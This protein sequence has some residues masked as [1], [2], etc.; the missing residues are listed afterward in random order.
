MPDE[1]DLFPDSIQAKELHAEGNDLY[2]KGDFLGAIDRFTQAL[3][4]WP[5]LY[6]AYFNRAL[7]RTRIQDYVPALEDLNKCVELNPGA[8]DAFYTRGLVREYRGD[9]PQAALDYARAVSQKPDYDKAFSQLE[10]CVNKALDLGRRSGG[11]AQEGTGAKD[12]ELT[13][14]EPF[15]EKVSGLSLDDYGGDTEHKNLIRRLCK[16]F[17][18]R[19]LIKKRGGHLPGGILLHGEPG[20]GKTYLAKIFANEVDAAFYSIRSSDI[21]SKWLGDSSKNM[22]NLFD[23]AAKHDHAVIFFDEIDAIASKRSL[24][25]DTL[26]AERRVMSAL[27][28]SMDGITDKYENVIVLGATNDFEAL[29]PALRRPGR[30]DH[31]LK[32][33]RPNVDAL[34]EI[35]KIQVR[36]VRQRADEPLIAD[37]IDCVRLARESQGFVGDDVKEVVERCVNREIL[38]EIDSDSSYQV[39]TSQLI[40][41]IEEYKKDKS[42]GKHRPIGFLDST[43][44]PEVS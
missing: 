35:Y 1:G 13:S 25:H 19:D 33:E 3:Q 16:L 14:F 11:S 12:S 32:I 40:A 20:T 4:L 22:Q 6:E 29:D 8:H 44:H 10:V 23:E 18:H 7:A 42:E 24:D 30:F 39:T 27:L 21:F 2:R 38:T 17:S 5:E 37:D 26:R 9:Y 43:P 31:I 28:M 34:H 36:L 15:M 41:E